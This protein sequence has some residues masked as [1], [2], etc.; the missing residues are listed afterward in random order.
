MQKSRMKSK[1]SKR[2]LSVL[3][4]VLLALL[5]LV[6]FMALVEYGFDLNSN[7][8][9]EIS[10]IS[11]GCS[12]IVGK[13]IHTINNEEECKVRCFSECSVKNKEYFSSNFTLGN[14]TCNSCAC[15]CK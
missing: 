11:D 9:I 6:I 5:A 12:Y 1:F 10:N 13:L 3:I 7:K 14:E 2:K 8:E 4:I 15:S